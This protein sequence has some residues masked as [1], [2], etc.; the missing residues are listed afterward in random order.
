MAH[1]LTLIYPLP[2]AEVKKVCPWYFQM[3]CI[4][5]ERPNVKPVGI[6]NSASE[7]DLDVLA[8]STQ[9]DMSGAE[10]AEPVTLSENDDDDEVKGENHRHARDKRSASI[11]GLDED[12]KP[13][14]VTPAR[15]NVS[16]PTGAGPKP[17]KVKG[18]E[19]LV[20][21]S[22]AEEVTRQKELDLDIQ[23]SKDKARKVQAK[24]ELQKVAIEAKREKTRQTHE[25]EMLKLQL[26][27]AKTRQAAP[28]VG[29]GIP[30]QHGQS[31]IHPPS[32]YPPFS[33]SFSFGDGSQFDGTASGNEGT[34]EGSFE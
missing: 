6:G 23:R 30:T 26:E 7:L 8:P 15:P 27:L 28:G 21:I 1:C 29:V 18:L 24:V 10:D 33:S 13:K 31:S 32:L 4:I 17:K 3:K 34:G 9:D 2:K 12:I 14:L 5:G 20:E 19:D 22:V 25:M 16:K 11:A